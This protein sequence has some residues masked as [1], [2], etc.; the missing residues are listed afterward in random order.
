MFVDTN[1]AQKVLLVITST[2]ACKHGSEVRNR[3][4][5]FVLRSPSLVIIHASMYR[6]V[7]EDASLGKLYYL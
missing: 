4:M 7:F 2:V 3:P 6:G 5:L 1:M